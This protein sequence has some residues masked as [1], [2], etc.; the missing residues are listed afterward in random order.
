MQA[1]VHFGTVFSNSCL[2][3]QAFGVERFKKNLTNTVLGFN[4][5][6]AKMFPQHNVGTLLTEPV[7]P[8]DARKER[9]VS[10]VLF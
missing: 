6:L 4:H 5:V 10:I 8:M 2:C 3:F 9:Y 7:S 1:T